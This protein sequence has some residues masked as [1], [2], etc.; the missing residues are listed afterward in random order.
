[1]LKRILN[2]KTGSMPL[3]MIGLLFIMLVFSL[4]IMEVG[5]L[6]ERHDYI[7]AI[8]QRS[9]NSAL[10]KNIP[11]KYRQDKIVIFNTA[12][13]T[14][15]LESYIAQ[16]N[17][18]NGNKYQVDITEIIAISDTEAE[19]IANGSVTKQPHLQ[20]KGTMVIPSVFGSASFNVGFTAFATNYHIGDY[21]IPI[22]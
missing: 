22:S 18:G 2:D 9:C 19:I 15:D 17:E 13:A 16:F 6:I 5:G 21:Q 20:V 12:Q 8:V 1:M 10:E 14:A 3:F 11:D 7:L 4:F